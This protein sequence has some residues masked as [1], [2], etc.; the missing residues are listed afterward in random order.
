[1]MSV[2]VNTCGNKL[3]RFAHRNHIYAFLQ[4][5]VFQKY[6]NF[7]YFHK[8]GRLIQ[9]TKHFC[10]FHR[11][12]QTGVICLAVNYP[13]TAEPGR[14]QLILIYTGRFTFAITLLKTF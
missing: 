8:V 3:E 12:S 2:V 5:K 1:M 7:I 11:L 4:K 6:V 13:I 14:S 10:I 9:Y